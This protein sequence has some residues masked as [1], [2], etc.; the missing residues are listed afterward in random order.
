MLFL[1]RNFF[2]IRGFWITANSLNYNALTQVAAFLSRNFYSQSKYA[3]AS[4]Q[5]KK[6]KKHMSDT[7]FRVTLLSQVSL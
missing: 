1:D 2:F 6:S 3:H 5:N 4:N 7:D